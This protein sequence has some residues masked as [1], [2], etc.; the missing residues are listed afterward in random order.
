MGDDFNDMPSPRRRN[1]IIVATGFLG[2]LAA[3]LVLAARYYELQR[4]AA[5]ADR[6]Q[7]E[8]ERAR[9]EFQADG[10]AS[11]FGPISLK[12]LEIKNGAMA[13]FADGD[14]ILKST[15]MLHRPMAATKA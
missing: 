3:V 9:K 6:A 8:A 4:S 13:S 12:S 11:A 5:E 10:P 7:L 1:W 15:D 14:L 2:L